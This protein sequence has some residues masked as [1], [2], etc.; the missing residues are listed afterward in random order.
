MRDRAAKLLFGDVLMHD[1]LDDIGA[2]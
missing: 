2:E 1:R